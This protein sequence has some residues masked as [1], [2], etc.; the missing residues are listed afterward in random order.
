MDIIDTIGFNGPVIITVITIIQ[1]FN[2]YPYL[3]SFCVFNFINNKLNEFLKICFREPRPEKIDLLKEQQKSIITQILNYMDFNKNETITIHPSHIYGMPSG[4]AQTG[5]FALGFL[6]FVQ[7]PR[8]MFMLACFVFILSLYERWNTK[9]HTM[10][11][12]FIGSIVGFIFAGF[13]Y[14]GTKNYLYTKVTLSDMTDFIFK[15]KYLD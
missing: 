4:H 15:S 13:A 12:L 9:K 8:P 3:I 6:Y 7:K 11:Q 1:L 2:Q 10:F 5:G 14:Y